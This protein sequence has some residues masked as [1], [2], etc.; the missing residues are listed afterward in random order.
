M[1]NCMVVT[2]ADY[3]RIFEAERAQDYPVVD[4]FEAV[5]DYWRPPACWRVR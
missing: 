1:N 2:A 4:D 5:S 3:A